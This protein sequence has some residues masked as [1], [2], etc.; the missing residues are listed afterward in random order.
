MKSA[1]KSTRRNLPHIQSAGATY[2]VTSSLFGALPVK[3]ISELKEEFQRKLDEVKITQPENADRRI[4]VLNSHYFKKYDAYLDKALH[5]PTYFEQPQIA[6]LLKEQFHRFDGEFYDLLAYT[7]MPNHFHL[8]IDTSVQL[9]TEDLEMDEV[10]DSYVNLSKIMFR[11]KGA[12]ARYCNLALGRI[13]SFWMEEYFDRIVRNEKDQLYYLNYI[14]QNS[15]EAGI[16][17]KWV[18]FP[19]T[20]LK[21]KEREPNS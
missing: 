12:S 8:L 3:V 14:L 10:P 1:H 20:F 17:K 11:I 9:A 2:F 13:G 21:I 18:D 7:I 15:V 16:V 5:G 19:H 6:E 4:A